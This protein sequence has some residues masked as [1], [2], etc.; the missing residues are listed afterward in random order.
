IDYLV[1]SP[2]AVIAGLEMNGGNLSDEKLG[3]FDPADGKH[4]GNTQVAD[5]TT[6][7]KA[8]FVQSE[9]ELEK[10]T[11]TAGVRFDHYNISD[12]T[13]ES[14]D[15]SGNV[16]S[17]RVNLLANLSPYL[18]FRAGFGRGF[19]APQIFDED[20]HIETSGSRK[21]IHKN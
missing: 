9:W 19:R 5:Q 10:L 14:T 20:L 15:I 21:V 4:Y 6:A 1:F 12:K 7:T 16:F 18:Q 13:R 3:Y 8:G 17:P 2:A 11:F